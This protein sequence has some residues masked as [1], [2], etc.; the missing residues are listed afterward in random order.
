MPGSR[1]L[2][3]LLQQSTPPCVNRL[4]GLRTCE[5]RLTYPWQRAP[6]P[7]PQTTGN[8]HMCEGWPP[9]C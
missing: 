4:A 5:K 6:A 2:A 7:D 3:T 9:A 8:A 1:M